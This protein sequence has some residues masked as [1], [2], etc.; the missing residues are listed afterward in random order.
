[1]IHKG[2]LKE[3]AIGVV[4]Y[5]CRVPTA[6]NLADGPSRLDFS[7]CYRLGA[8][9]TDIDLETLRECTLRSRPGENDYLGVTMAPGHTPTIQKHG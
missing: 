1:M 9:Q 4:P 5:F 2:T 8:S 3:A 7:M 6:S